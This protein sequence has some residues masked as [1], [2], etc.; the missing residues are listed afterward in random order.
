M[1]V[2]RL[3]TEVAPRFSKKRRPEKRQINYLWISARRGHRYFLIN[4]CINK[5]CICVEGNNLAG[6]VCL[7]RKS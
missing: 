3:V 4:M 5:G 6:S 2:C 1:S 7:L